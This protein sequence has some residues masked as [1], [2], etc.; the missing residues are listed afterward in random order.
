VAV[1]L[2]HPGWVK[3]D[4]GGEAAPLDVATSV[5][6]M[7]DVIASHAGKPGVSYVDYA[8]HTLPW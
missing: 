7:A 8:G 5:R 3:T 4:M 2:M 1:V 6:G